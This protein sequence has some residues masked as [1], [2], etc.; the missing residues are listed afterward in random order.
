MDLTEEQW[1]VLEPLSGEMPRHTDGRGRPWRSIREVLNGIRWMLRTGAQWA[2]LPERYPPYQTCHRR[3]QRWVREGV[4]ARI[5]EA[6]ATDL[7]ARGGLDLSA[8]FIDGTFIVAKKGRMRGSDQA[9][10]R[11]EAHGR[12]EAVATGQTALV[13][14]SPSVSPGPPRLRL[15]RVVSSP[16]PSTPAS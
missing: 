15:T 3:Y 1:H 13:Y 16:P 10:H 12:S 5:L 4:F 8:C 14:L 11:D 2:D 9:G 7:K 6:L